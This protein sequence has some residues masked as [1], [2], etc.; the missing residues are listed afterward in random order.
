[1]KKRFKNKKKIKSFAL[2]IICL[3]VFLFQSN[4]QILHSLPM[5]NYKSQIVIEELRLK[6][7]SKYKEVWLK[8][9]KEVWESWLSVQEGFLGRQIFWDKEKEES[10]ILVSWE[11]KKLWKSI[12][13]QEVNDV[14]SKFE[15][16]V[17][18][19]LKVTENPFKLIYEGEL[20][21]Q[22]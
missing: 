7:P 2:L 11:N 3:S 4:S 13:M 20:E 9:E 21:K 22:V 10:L 1:M 17:L 14:Q 16:I 5:D 12:S 18:N 19:T 15:E 8:A 6:V